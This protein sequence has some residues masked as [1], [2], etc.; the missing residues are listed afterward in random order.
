MTPSQTSETLKELDHRPRKNL[1]QNFLVDSNIVDKSIRLA[2]VVRDDQIV[3]IGPG[4]GTLTESLLEAGAQVWAIEFDPTLAN[5]LRTNLSPAHS[6]TLHLTE[7]DALDHPRAGLHPSSLSEKGFKV[8][9]NLPYAISTPW[10]DAMLVRPLATRMVLMLQLEAADRFSA[11]PGGKQFGAISIF[12]QSVYD[13][14]PG[15][16]VPANCFHPR[17]DVES[18][19]LNIRLKSDPFLFDPATKILI[20]ECFQQRRKQIGALLKKKLGDGGAEWIN[21]LSAEGLDYR[22]RPEQIP[23]SAWQRLKSD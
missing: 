19:L 10:L 16:K 2:E 23:I 21:S 8:V 9:A 18:Y 3:E 14:E 12:L 1:G 20:R 13:I 4:L 15:H 17:P 11:K 7:G 5:H 22:A 6:D